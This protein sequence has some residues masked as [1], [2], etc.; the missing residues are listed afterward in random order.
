MCCVW[1]WACTLLGA[2][3]VDT[4]GEATDISDVDEV[5]PDATNAKQLKKKKQVLL[6]WSCLTGSNVLYTVNWEI[7]MSGKFEFVIFVYK[8]FQIPAN[9]S[10]I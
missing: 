7:F 4:D 5:E 6:S 9:L 10:K 3:G 1:M 2:K 8:Y